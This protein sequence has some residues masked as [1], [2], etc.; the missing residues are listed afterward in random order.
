MVL[1]L[2]LHPAK[3]SSIQAGFTLIEVIVTIALIGIIGGTAVYFGIDSFRGYSFHSDRDLLV[4]SLQH[5]RSQAIGNNCLGS[6]CTDG[7]PHGVLIQPDKFVVFQGISFATADHDVDVIVE[8]NPTITKSG[9]S[10]V[11]FKQLSGDVS[12]VG[13]IVLTDSV[14]RVSTTTVGS[15]GQILWTN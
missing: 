2:N 6:S 9:L 4:T 11:V 7:K 5:A 13:D 10:E 1:P 14:G 15:E 8:A 3:S 12:T